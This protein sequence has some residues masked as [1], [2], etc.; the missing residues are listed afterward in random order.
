MMATLADTQPATAQES[1]STHAYSA[2]CRE[3]LPE[4][5]RLEQLLD[6]HGAL[7]RSTVLTRVTDG[8][9]V[10]PVY[11]L[12]LGC[13][14]KDCPVVAFVGGVH[15]VE[16]IGTEIL[17]AFLET[18]CQRLGWD[19]G[20]QQELG[21]VRLV[22]LPLLNPVGMAHGWRANGNGIDLMRNAPLNARD[23]TAW[24]V[25]GHRLSRH[26]PWYR[27]VETEGMESEA[28]ALCRWVE[29]Q[30]FPSPFTLVLDIHS[31]FGLRDR[32]WFPFAGSTEPPY[33]LAEFAAFNELLNTT[34]PHH[35]YLVEP[36]H[37]HYISHGDL[38]DYLYLRSIES[39][40][41][42]FLPFTLEIGSWLWVKKNPR[43]LVS[44][45]GLF[46][47]EV[48]HRRQRAQRRH[49]FLLDFLI[50]AS[51]SSD[52]W[53]PARNRRFHYQLQAIRDWYA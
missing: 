36:Q 32:L 25:G 46:N 48:P 49:Q 28:D 29:Q 16:R 39:A 35:N 53:L 38:W 23:K 17:L 43:Q 14:S 8:D 44:F 42:P 45:R 50:R 22:F 18:L 7:L 24:L 2:Y 4:L 1:E 31:G 15:G 30:L 41:G 6:T 13:S 5:M 19:Q 51:R 9:R 27:G 26:L 47:P 52:N 12:E 10:L 3:R 34:Y 33:H 37:D 20:L 40:K 21:K 11:A